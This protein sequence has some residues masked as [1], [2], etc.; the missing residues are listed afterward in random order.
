MKSWKIVQEWGKEI[1]ET[2]KRDWFKN[3]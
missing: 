1:I 3:F 2:I